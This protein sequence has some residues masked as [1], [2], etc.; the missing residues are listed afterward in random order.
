ML[1][2]NTR[3]LINVFVKLNVFIQCAK[4]LFTISF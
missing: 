2:L 4:Q 1:T 3:C